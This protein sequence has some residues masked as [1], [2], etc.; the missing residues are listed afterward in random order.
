MRARGRITVWF[1]CDNGMKQWDNLFPMLFSVFVNDIVVEINNFGLGVK[2]DDTTV[3]MLSYA[4]NIILIAKSK[5][6]LYI[7]A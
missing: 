1:K 3:S 4:C 2:I 7:N 6:D 5:H